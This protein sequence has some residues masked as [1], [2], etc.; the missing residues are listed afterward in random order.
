[1][2]N[3]LFWAT[4]YPIIALVLMIMGFVRDPLY[5]YGAVVIGLIAYYWIAKAWRIHS[6]IKGMEWEADQ[7]AK[8]SRQF[9]RSRKKRKK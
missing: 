3:N 2:D 7:R 1:M 5:F 9:K 4:A 8:R 6:H